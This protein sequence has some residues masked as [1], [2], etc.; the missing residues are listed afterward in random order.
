MK[1][2][3]H[4]PMCCE[5]GVPQKTKLLDPR[6]NSTVTFHNTIWWIWRR[7]FFQRWWRIDS[8]KNVSFSSDDENEGSISVVEQNKL[9]TFITFRFSDVTFPYLCFPY[10]HVQSCSLFCIVD[11]SCKSD[12]NRC[13]LW[14]GSEI[15]CK[16]FHYV[17]LSN[18]ITWSC[19]K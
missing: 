12:I 4:Q 17:D 7:I 18:M 15:E 19:K 8:Q 16:F 3:H 2:G 14:L 11:W 13:L 5:D 1:S 6:A 9:N 10:M